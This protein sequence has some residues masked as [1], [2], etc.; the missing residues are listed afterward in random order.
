[1]QIAIEL[2]KSNDFN[3]MLDNARHEASRKLS[4]SIDIYLEQNNYYAD[5]D[6]GVDNSDNIEHVQSIIAE[7]LKIIVEPIASGMSQTIINC[8]VKEH[9]TY[10]NDTLKI[11]TEQLKEAKFIDSDNAIYQQ[12]DLFANRLIAARLDETLFY[13]YIETLDGEEQ[14]ELNNAIYN[15]ILLVSEKESK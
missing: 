9:A 5:D 11:F 3:Y 7:S 8:F 10:I 14:K 6:F 13:W 15:Q 2:M 4:N 1:M 12:C